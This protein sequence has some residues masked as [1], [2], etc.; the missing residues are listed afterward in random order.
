PQ[1]PIPLVEDA[2]TGTGRAKLILSISLNLQPVTLRIRNVINLAQCFTNY[3]LEKQ[4]EG[5]LLDNEKS[6]CA[7]GICENI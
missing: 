1:L 5:N 7:G 3:H 4:K 2:T 6:I